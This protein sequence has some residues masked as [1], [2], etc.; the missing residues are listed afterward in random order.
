MRCIQRLGLWHHRRNLVRRRSFVTPHLQIPTKQTQIPN[1]EGTGNLK[2]KRHFSRRLRHQMDKKYTLY[3]LAV[4]CKT[5][6]HREN[7]QSQQCLH[8][9]DNPQS[10]HNA[11]ILHSAQH[12][13]R[14]HKSLSSWHSC[15]HPQCLTQ[16]DTRCTAYSQHQT[17]TMQYHRRC[18][19]CLDMW[20][21]HHILRSTHT[22]QYL[23]SAQHSIRKHKSLSSWH[24]CFH[25]QCL[26][27]QD[28]RCT[29][30]SQ[31]QTCTMQYH[32]RCIQCLD[33]WHHHHILR[34]THTDQYLHSAQHSIRTYKRFRIWQLRRQGQ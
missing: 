16:Q 29:A 12:S 4:A 11:L 14:K 19:Q 32:R 5:L 24:S 21:H 23:H 25:P 3:F 18:I 30:Y 1:A 28:T 15:F 34:S 20:H 31:H 13:I 7:S 22:D 2:Q 17:C 8:R 6:N 27:Q 33:M 9:R 10:T 26:T